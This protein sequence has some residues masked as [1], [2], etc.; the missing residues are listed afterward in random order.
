MDTVFAV[1]E[2]S[3]NDRDLYEV[4][5]TLDSA[6]AT[7]VGLAEHYTHVH[8]WTENRSYNGLRYWGC[9]QQ[10]TWKEGGT[11]FSCETDIIEYALLGKK[12]FA[13]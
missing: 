13:S 12:E 7:Q 8:V 2:G 10:R 1:L 5:A 3:Y 6:M 9:D 11:R 4:H